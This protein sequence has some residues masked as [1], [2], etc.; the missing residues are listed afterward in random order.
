MASF[1]SGGHQEMAEMILWLLTVVIKAPLV[2]SGSWSSRI[3][4]VPSAFSGSLASL[5]LPPWLP[6]VILSKLRR[7][8]SYSQDTAV[9]HFEGYPV[10]FYDYDVPSKD[11]KP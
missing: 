1:G 11:I 8:E 10:G 6:P 2:F 3:L 5:I 7:R 4:K 9:S